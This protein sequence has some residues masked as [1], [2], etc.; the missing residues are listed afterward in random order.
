MSEGI[1]KSQAAGHISTNT[2]LLGGDFFPHLYR[3]IKYSIKMSSDVPELK[4]AIYALCSAEKS[5]GLEQLECK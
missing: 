4:I 1:G 2:H 3:S 5:T